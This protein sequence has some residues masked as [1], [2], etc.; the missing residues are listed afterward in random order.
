MSDSSP[1]A[2]VKIVNPGKVHA[3]F[4]G[5]ATD[6][7]GFGETGEAAVLEALWRFAA[8]ALNAST[9]ITR[10]LRKNKSERMDNFMIFGL[11]LGALGG[12]F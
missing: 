11:G 3:G 4:E 12:R 6:T 2:S 9:A 10:R 5:A 8:C 1:V 7:P